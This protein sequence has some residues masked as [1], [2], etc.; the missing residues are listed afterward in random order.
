MQRVYVCHDHITGIFSAIYDA[1]KERRET[2]DAGIAFW[3][4]IEQRLFCEY[5]QCEEREEKAI[6]VEKLIKK[7]LGMEAYWKLYHA[8]LSADPI[9]GDAVLGTMFAARHLKDSRKIMENLTNPSVEKVFELSRK[10]TN[11]AHYFKEFLRFKE[12]ENGIL[13]ARIDPKSQILT[14]IAPHFSDR[15]PLE[16]WMIYDGTHEM[17][18]VHEARKNWI[19]VSNV[20]ADMEKL[21]KLSESEMAIRQLWR[22][23]FESI[24]IDERESYKRQRQHLPIWYRKNMVEFQE[25]PTQK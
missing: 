6:A 16:N 1:W 17:F 7:H 9:K 24:S 22:G 25:L 12:L 14:C 2:G 4:N 11:E 20:S 10:V 21:E 23:F 19:L 8:A 13:Y 5:V 15:L 18:V 3:G